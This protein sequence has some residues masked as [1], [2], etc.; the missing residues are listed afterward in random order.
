[1]L[2]DD[3][4]FDIAETE[5]DALFLMANLYPKT[6][7]LPRVVY[8]SERGQARHDVRVKVSGAPGDKMRV[9]EMATMSVRPEPRLL[10]GALSREEEQLIARWIKL[11]AAALIDYW[12]ETIDTEDLLARLQR[13]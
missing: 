3:A 2:L 9:R 6:T 7:G 1:M 8:A 10:H 11:N 4:V 13:V 12:N 5:E